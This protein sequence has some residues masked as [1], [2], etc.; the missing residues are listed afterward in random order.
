M[1]RALNLAGE[2]FERQERIVPYFEPKSPRMNGLRLLVRAGVIALGV[3][4]APVGAE[5]QAIGHKQQATGVEQADLSQLNEREII[6]N[7][8]EILGRDAVE[9]IM[10]LRVYIHEQ[11]PGFPLPNPPEGLAREDVDRESPAEKLEVLQQR[12]ASKIDKAKRAKPF[13]AEAKKRGLPWS[14]QFDQYLQIPAEPKVDFID[15]ELKTYSNY[16]LFE[17]LN[18]ILGGNVVE[19]I[20]NPRI[21]MGE[22]RPGFAVRSAN[23]L[24]SK[25]LDNESP[26]RKLVK[27]QKAREDKIVLVRHLFQIIKEAQRRN[28]S[29]SNKFGQYLRI[30]LEPEVDFADGELASLSNL[31]LINKVIEILGPRAAKLISLNDSYDA[32]YGETP[33]DNR[34]ISKEMVDKSTPYIVEAHKRGLSW[35]DRVNKF[36]VEPMVNVLTV[37]PYQNDPEI[38]KHIKELELQLKNEYGISIRYGDP[39]SNGYTGNVPNLT[40]IKSELIKLSKILAKYPKNVIKALR[41]TSIDFST[42][43]KN[44]GKSVGGSG[45]IGNLAINSEDGVE[46]VFDHEF[47][48]ILDQIDGSDI[49]NP[50]WALANPKGMAEYP[51]KTGYDSIAAGDDGANESIPPT[52]Y[53]YTYGKKGGPNEDQ[54]TIAQSLLSPK[55][56]K[57]IAE[58]AKTDKVLRS[59]IEMMTGCLFDQTKGEFSRQLTQKEYKIKFR[60]PDFQYYAKWSRTPDGTFSMGPDFW[61]SIINPDQQNSGKENSNS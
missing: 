18:K 20:I 12:R 25:D 6:N 55:V 37:G 47:Y 52:G 27:L 23:V 4:S 14:N 26:S 38:S 24:T 5:A 40:V 28:L 3:L 42:N 11:R 21:S 15:S 53:A 43:L 41:Y 51:F 59:K 32:Y 22:E 46:W 10:G 45:T 31:D 57:S 35:V 7:L 36:F 56:A 50:K 1:S 17:E 60:F 34:F 44:W 48:H 29:W 9:E 39:H 33:G 61:N 54:A 8:E 49:D 58:R 30:P 19:E 2:N 16:A 13:I